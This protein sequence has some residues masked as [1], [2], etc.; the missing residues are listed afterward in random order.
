M[1][2]FFLAAGPDDFLPRKSG[3]GE[4]RGSRGAL[5]VTRHWRLAAGERRRINDL[6]HDRVYNWH[7]K[8]DHRW[9]TNK[10]RRRYQLHIRIMSGV[11]WVST[12]LVPL[13]LR[14]FPLGPLRLPSGVPL[15]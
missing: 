11:S 2:V 6:S 5:V 10:R 13:H 9:L 15:K 8:T 7:L 1:I 4:L 14:P 12:V 3:G